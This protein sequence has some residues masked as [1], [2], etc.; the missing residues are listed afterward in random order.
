ME[1][2]FVRR[3]MVAAVSALFLLLAACEGSTAV[4]SGG[5]VADQAAG[6]SSPGPPAPTGST[7]G[8]TSDDPGGAGGAGAVG[9][10]VYPDPFRGLGTWIDIYDVRAW[11]H[12]ERSVRAMRDRGVRTI[13]LQ[14]SNFSRGRQFVHL[15]GVDRFLD[16]APRRGITVVAWYLPGLRDLE[17]D[18]KRSLAAIGRTTANGNRF[19]GFALDIESAVVENHEHRTR[20]LIGLSERLRRIAGPH[21]RLGA[22]VPSPRRLRTDRTYWPSFPYRELADMYDAFLPMTYFTYRVSGREGAAWYTSKNIRILRQETAGLRVPIHVIGGI[23]S[24]ATAAETRGFVDAVRSH[25]V[26]G[27]S[28]YTFPMIR[29]D[30]WSE[31]AVIE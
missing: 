22:I 15:E 14:T 28:Y 30:Q 11:R 12:P 18:L 25:E 6:R 29:S 21:Y 9:P 1:I 3:R 23:A 8:Q 26:A 16:A 13:Y 2:R 5:H 7:A 20:R 24:H 4:V 31:L 19:G 17:T 27:A 10:E